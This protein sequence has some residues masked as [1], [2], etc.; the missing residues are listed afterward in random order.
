LKCLNQSS[1]SFSNE[2][3]DETVI[4]DEETYMCSS[5]NCDFITNNALKHYKHEKEHLR[6]CKKNGFKSFKCRKC[7]FCAFTLTDLIYHNTEHNGT[8]LC[9]FDNCFFKTDTKDK[10]KT[11]L[12]RH[13]FGKCSDCHKYSLCNCGKISCKS[14]K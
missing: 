2:T 8:Y 11:H 1:V 4:L 13:D 7:D 9:K 12:N 3:D 14:L 5:I 6:K 10:L